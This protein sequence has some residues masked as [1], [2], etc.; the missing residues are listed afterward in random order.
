MK[1]NVIKYIFFIIIAVL[2]IFAIYKVNNND[3][4]K[5]GPNGSTNAAQPQEVTKEIKIAVAGLD[6][7]NP[8]LSK[9]KNVQE[10][11]KLIFE[12]L[13]NITQDYKAEPCL[14]TEWAKAD[15]NSYILK[16]REDVKWSN[17]EKF[18]SEDVRFT[19]DRL[20]ENQSIYSYNVQY[21]TG[22]DIVDD[23]TVRIK[24]DRDIAFFEYNLAFPIMSRKYFEGQDFTNTEKNKNPIGT[25][26]FKIGEITESNITLDK[27]ENW[28]NISNKN[29]IIE[30][31]IINTNSSMAEVYNAFKMENID[32]VNTSNLNY[33]DYVGTL[34][35]STKEYVGREH[36]FLVLNTK[37]GLLSNVEVRKAILASID[38]SNIVGNVFGGKYYTSDFPLSY[39]SW[40][41]NKSDGNSTYNAANVN[42]ILEEDGWTLRRENWQKTINHKTQ[43]LIVNLLVKSSD[44]TRVN[45][46]NVIQNQLAQ[47]GIGVN[48]QSVS[49]SQF[50]NNINSKNYDMVLMVS[51][52]SASPNLATY[53]GD[54]NYA[55][56]ENKEVSDI[57]KEVSNS[58]DENTLKEKYKRLKEIYKSD[59]PYISLYFSKNVAIY[60]TSL[61]GEVNPNW[62]N[63]FY[64]I[65]NWYK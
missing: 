17:G 4:D 18:N 37:S 19:I 57:M 16:L 43:K 8:I 35:Y 9:N 2:L 45:V 54:N 42:K 23:N 6:T 50:N 46:A 63:I 52:V 5:S 61:A 15:G 3:N 53:F 47:V 24:L 39:G 48:I 36:G 22:V 27:N 28:W 51:E 38:K 59:V 33:T 10:V 44:N 25:G 65:E 13:V 56:Y 55:N 21:V 11:T 62:Y 40:L 41:D 20:K 7:I 14:A 31:V 26:M 34:G 49:D 58:T 64:N 29:S 12:P 30:K 32:F 1:G 60:N